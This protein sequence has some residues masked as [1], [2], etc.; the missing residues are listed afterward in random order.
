MLGVAS[1]AVVVTHPSHP[2]LILALV[3][4]LGFTAT[5]LLLRRRDPVL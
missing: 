3:F 5:G 1:V 2:D 4:G